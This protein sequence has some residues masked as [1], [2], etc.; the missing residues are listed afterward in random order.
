MTS[1]AEI[2]VVRGNPTDEELAAAIAVARSAN[3]ADV[4]L[5]CVPLGMY[6]AVSD[7]ETMVA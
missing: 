7:S 2:S 6:T 4:V 1:P 3:D 5:I